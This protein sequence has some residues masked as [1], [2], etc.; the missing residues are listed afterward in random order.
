MPEVSTRPHAGATKARNTQSVPTQGAAPIA[1]E[2]TSLSQITLY[3]RPKGARFHEGP[4]S[5]AYEAGFES[6]PGRFVAGLVSRDTGETI[7]TLTPDGNGLNHP[8]REIKLSIDPESCAIEWQAGT[9][10]ARVAGEYAILI[11]AKV[12]DGFGKT[13]SPDGLGA[14]GSHIDK[15]INRRRAE[16]RKARKIKLPSGELRELGELSFQHA[17]VREAG[18]RKSV[19]RSV[20]FDCQP[21]PYYQ[22]YVRGVEMAE[23]VIAYYKKHKEPDLHI[24]HVLEAAFRAKTEKRSCEGDSKNG[25]AQ[26]FLTVM[27]VLIRVG[28]GNINPKWIAQQKERAVASHESMEAYGRLKKAEFVAR[29]RAARE[30]KKTRGAA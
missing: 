9:R 27:A 17:V 10:L 2:H 22:G 7:A 13:L 8:V 23:E 20:D 5:R 16:A 24:E 14:I 25:Q 26:G 29:M 4:I 18:S 15:V 28:A 3:L 1:A 12:C 6:L 30:A 21:M 11:G 19:W